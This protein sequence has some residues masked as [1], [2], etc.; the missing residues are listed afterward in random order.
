MPRES[1]ERLL[2][3]RFT[4]PLL[5]AG[6]LLL[7]LANEMSYLRTVNALR[8]GIALTDARI[9]T[10]RVLQLLTDAETG[11]RGY[12]LT[13]Q[14]EYL[15]TLNQAKIELPKATPQLMDFLTSTGA[16]GQADA[17]KI[18]DAI[19]AKLSE[20]DNT[21]ALQ[22][23]GSRAAALT[24]FDSGEDKRHMDNLRSIFEGKLSQA[25]SLQQDAREFIYRTLW[26][27]RAII[28]ALSLILVIGLYLHLLQLRRSD[29][30]RSERQQLLEAQVRERTLRLQT[31]AGYLQTVREDEKSRLAREL[32]DELGGVLTAGKLTLARA[33]HRLS[34]DPTMAELLAKVGHHLSEGIAMKR[35]IIED[36][37]P[38]T[39]SALGLTTALAILSRD[40][41]EQLGVPVRAEIA[42][43]HFSPDVELSIYRLVQEAL[44]N[45]GKYA[46]AS[47]VW[48]RLK[49]EAGALQ[50]EIADNG[51]GFDT[52]N[53]RVGS[54]G[55][56]G[57]RFRIESLG[58]S[59]TVVSGVGQGTRIFATVPQQ[60]NQPAAV[61]LDQNLPPSPMKPA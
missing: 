42:E 17:L 28:A 49:R 59:L 16:S 12:L 2:R 8:G 37:R 48:V 23:A 55:L 54:H 15:D 11:Q 25:A 31:L 13:G 10:A 46:Q 52:A 56:D 20:L 53:L 36:L 57:M 58:G 27:N 34:A 30:E 60:F 47:E 44:T 21:I 5:I 61:A 35:K 33:Q 3:R 19:S 50:I 26:L 40:V 43:C 18:A 1:L 22:Q 39:L 4:L 24:L 9:A 45:I 14:A 41:S 32:H 51:K 7:M 29:R 38:T 6:V